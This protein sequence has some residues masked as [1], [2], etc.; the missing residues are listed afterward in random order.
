MGNLPEWVLK[1]R[2]SDSESYSKNSNDLIKALAIAWGAMSASIELSGQN[3]SDE[4][5]REA[6]ERIKEL[7]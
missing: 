1:M 7:K 2:W 3:C 6:M 5:L 4:P